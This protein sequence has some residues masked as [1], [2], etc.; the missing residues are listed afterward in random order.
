MSLYPKVLRDRKRIDPQVLPPSQFISRLMQLPM[1][2]T[3][4]RYGEF[5]ADFE[6]D[7]LRLRK[8]QVMGIAGLPA[9]D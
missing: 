6:T 7:C 5:I 2:P 4:K 1:M 3:A 9:A 8:S